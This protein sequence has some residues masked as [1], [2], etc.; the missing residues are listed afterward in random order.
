[1]LTH[2]QHETL[3]S[4]VQMQGPTWEMLRDEAIR[5]ESHR[6][7]IISELV[8]EEQDMHQNPDLFQEE[9]PLCH[10]AI[11]AIR[12]MPILGILSLLKG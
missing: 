1:M 7:A 6:A 10:V 4:L 3:A 12:F 5:D 9:T 8:Q 11:H 2:K